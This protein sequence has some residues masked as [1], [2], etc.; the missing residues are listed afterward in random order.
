VP[1]L[2]QPTSPLFPLGVNT[3]TLTDPGPEIT[4]V[5]SVT[6]SL[7][8]LT[9]VAASDF[10]FTTSSEAGTKLLPVTVSTTPCCTSAKLTA[11]GEMEPI[12]G[13]GRTFPQKGFKALLQPAELKS[14]ERN[15]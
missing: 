8:E 15:H 12:M 2:E 5:L 11:L 14:S 6:W 7:L 1:P 13:A 3:F 9:S 4:A 10:P